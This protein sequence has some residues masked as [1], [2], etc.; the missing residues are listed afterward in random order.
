[1]VQIFWNGN[2]RYDLNAKSNDH[3]PLQLSVDTCITLLIT[4]ENE[5][6]AS[7]GKDATFKLK[8]LSIF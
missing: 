3:L 7:S 8:S 5:Y 6:S 4:T 2:R 1:M